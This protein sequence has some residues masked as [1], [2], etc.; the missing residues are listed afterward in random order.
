MASELRQHNFETLTHMIKLF[1][2]CLLI[3]A[4]SL[5]SGCALNKIVNAPDDPALKAI[6]GKQFAIKVDCYVFRY[7]Q[8]KTEYPYIDQVSE[9]AYTHSPALQAKAD[10]NDI[11]KNFGGHIILGIIPKG[12]KVHVVGLRYKNSFEIGN[13][14]SFLIALDDAELS[15]RWPILDATWL[16]NNHL[17]PPPRLYDEVIGISEAH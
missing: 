12:T 4:L 13:M 5:V 11:G 14:G 3:I 2:C 8:E 1:P 16:T 6:R 7:A 10:Q 15:K 9:I 17:G